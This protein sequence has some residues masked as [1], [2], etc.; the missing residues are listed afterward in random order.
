MTDIPDQ[1]PDLNEDAISQLPALQLLN[2]LGYTYLSPEAALRLRGERKKEVLLEGILVPWLRE[3]NQMRYKGQSYPISENNILAMVQALKDLPFDG[4]VRTNEKIY[5]LLC[6][7]KSV[8][9]SIDGDI[10]S[11]TLKFIDWEHPENNVYH[12]TEEFE[13]ERSGSHKLRVP[14][15]VLFVNGIPLCVIECKSPALKE[16][17]QQAISQQ[18]RNQKDGEIP[19]LFLYS[20]LLLALS[21][22]EARYA[23]TGTPAKFWAVWR[24]EGPAFE[25]D[26]E[27]AIQTP[28]SES[29]MNEIYALRK[30]MLKDSK[31][32]P[33]GSLQR[34][35][36]EQDR[37]LFA[38]CR[39]DRLLELTYRYILYDGGVKK[40]A[41]YQQYFCIKKTMTR[42]HVRQADNSRRGG[43][44]WHTQGSGKSLTMVLLA[45][46]IA[47]DTSIPDYKIVLVTD[48]VD[49]DDQIYKTFHHCGKEVEQATTGKHLLD[50]LQGG[51]QRIITTLIH[52]FDKAV[53]NPGAHLE[54]ANIFVLVDEGHR[55]QYGSFHAKMRKVL[56]KACYLGFTGTPVMKK[57]KDTLEK[58]G[59]LIDTYTID[60]AVADKAVVPLL[61]EGRHVEQTVNAQ[62]IDNW[63]QRITANLSEDQANDLKKKFATSDQLN[64]TEQK[65]MAVAWDISEH[66]QK[67][68]Q[69]TGF[70]GQL[71]TP[72]KRTAL[73]F[74]KYLDEFGM[75]SSEVLISG[76]DEREGEAD[77]Y[78]ENTQEVQRFWQGMMQKYGNEKEY[79]KQLINAFKKADEPEIIIV[80]DKLLTGFDA[81]R[82]TIL[83]LTR[84]LKEHTLLQAIARV[85]RLHDGKEFGYILDYRGVL[86]NLDQALELYS[87]L[88]GFE[89]SDLEHLL[90]DVSVEISTLPQKHS[91]LWE[92]F[93]EVKNKQDE[94]AYERLLAD[95]SLRDLF[96][97]RLSAY[98]R[99][100]AIAMSTVAFLEETPQA[101]ID[102]YRRDLKFFSK[103]RMAVRHRYAEV[104]DFSEYEP[105]IQKLLDT[106]VGTG[107]IETITPL[108]NI[109]DAEAFAEEV[110]K[111]AGVGS[112][113]DTIA[114]RTARTIHDKMQED[115]VFYQR[116]SDMLKAAIEAFRAERLKAN[117]YLKQVTEI[118]QAVLNRTG[119]K[120]PTVLEGHDVAKAYF[121]VLKEVL[122][123]YDIPDDLFAQTAMT[124]DKTIETLRIVNWSQDQDV[125]NRMRIDIE[126]L[127]FEF[128]TQ[129][130]QD[131]GFD[132]IDSLIEKCLDIAK[133][134]RA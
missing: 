1:T 50:L 73:L 49:L 34:Q 83:Y 121:G 60:K 52:K 91:I 85:N 15:L 95:E 9:Q 100:L 84:K 67:N 134:R 75:V 24:E 101:K 39:P 113:A 76:P 99:T 20:Q 94:E 3:H 18:I 74:K 23:T 19:Q 26:L 123:E 72:K 116:F 4:L 106:H 31:T 38:L 77:L 44:V 130:Q 62:G 41:R 131:F 37:T 109:F 88:D 59:G 81:P 56:P 133:A 115:P 63:F 25:K 103:L 82:N 114:H 16:P 27:A 8:Q 107:Q 42:I 104:V 22:N 108:V 86:E 125:Q 117:E 111:I 21:K 98:A 43:V 71:V 119:D 92:T 89:A 5:D 33:Y 68:W 40:I 124:I 46:S 97:E 17:I 10:K 105:K 129:S 79:N 35:P 6:L 58:F 55:G 47:L 30:F 61:Y 112:K 64:Q 80:V 69:G 57:D 126:D 51:K 96:Y 90:T 93:K 120:I 53:A 45:K 12:V 2:N 29:Q 102:R 11:P 110:E 78:D 128:K 87:D 32:Q 118:M 122:N 36:T 54:D 13:V 66:F 48:R 7:G 28:L 14:D 65:I 132:E 127:L 70:K